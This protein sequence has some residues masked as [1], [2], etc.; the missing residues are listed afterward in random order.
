MKDSNSEKPSI[1]NQIFNIIFKTNN[2]YLKIV[3]NLKLPSIFKKKYSLVILLLILFIFI[4]ASTGSS[5]DTNIP[6]F[7]VKKDVFLISITESGEIKAKNS[8]SIAAPRVRGSLKIVELV[9]EGNYVKPG[10]VVA[11]FDPTEA[12]VKLKDAEAQ[13]EISRSNKAKLEANHQSEMAQMESDLKSAELSFEL[14][15]LSL[16]QM[17]FEAE[18]KR[19]EAELQ[20]NKNVLNFEKTKQNFESKKIIQKSEMENMN[21]EIRQKISELEKAQRDL[22]ALSLTS[23]ADGLVVYGMNWSTG[24]KFQIGDQPWSGQ[25]IV[26]LPDLSQMESHTYVNEVDVSKVKVGQ[27]VEV[28]LD[29]FQDS[30]FVG[31]VSNVARLG[32]QKDNQSTIKVFDVFVEIKGVSEILKPGMTTSNKIIIDKIDDQIFI[33]HEALF[34]NEGEFFVYK[35]DGSGFDD[36]DVTIGNK[37]ED[38]IVVKS[39]LED[40]DVVALRDPNKEIANENLVENNSVQMPENGN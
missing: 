8:I 39:G 40:G 3:K 27:K 34:E 16:E 26:N 36:I 28:K 11:R 1:L 4:F 21:V 15:K 19:R 6:V 31:E 18:A 10:D 37:S 2:S 14:S 30:V 25:V 32:K 29:A 5:V 33:P 20:H 12:L 7:N 22:D 9:P 35:K 23:S 17:K 24:L 38:F 13:L